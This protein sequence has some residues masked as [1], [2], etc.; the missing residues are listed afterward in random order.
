MRPATKVGMLV[1]AGIGVGAMLSAVLPELP[2]GNGW[3]GIGNSGTANPTAIKQPAESDKADFPAPKT[4][5]QVS[6][7]QL[8]EEAPAPTARPIEATVDAPEVV[9]VIIKGRDY[10]VR[11]EP[12]DQKSET[13]KKLPEVIAA[14]RTATGD[15]NGVRV[16]IYQ[17]TSAKTMTLQAL[18]DQLD[19]A[20]IPRSAIRERDEPLY[21]E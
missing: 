6:D 1:A 17:T 11:K 20:K 3:F 21:E 9:Y 5:K 13:Y 15:E 4:V 14:A 16:R 10:F 7:P 18:K 19:V 12:E 2:F 8:E